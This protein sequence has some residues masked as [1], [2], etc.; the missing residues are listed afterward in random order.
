MTLSCAASPYRQAQLV[1]ALRRD[2]RHAVALALILAIMTW[3]LHSPVASLLDHEHKFAILLASAFSDLL[4][5]ALVMTRTRVDSP[6]SG[7]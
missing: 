3:T 7:H 2:H 4:L 5:G 6:P 1:Q